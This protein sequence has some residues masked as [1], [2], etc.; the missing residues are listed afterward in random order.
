MSNKPILSL[1]GIVKRFGNQTV[2]NDFQLEIANGEFFTILGPSGCGKTT[3]LRLM[4]GFE[5]PDEGRI[6]LD[7]TDIAQ[8]APE[9]RPVNTVFQSYALFPHMSVFDNVAFGLNMA[10]VDKAEIDTRV[11]DALAMVRL[12]DYADRQPHQLSGGQRQRVAIARAVVNRPKVLLLDESLSA[13][14]A[15]L[16]QQM[17]VELK[18]LQR[19]LG[20]TFIYV[21]HDQEEALSMSDRILVMDGG[22]AQQV[23]TPR[24]I[25]ECPQNVFVASFIGEINAIDGVITEQ[26]EDLRYI[27]KMADHHRE[28]RTDKVFSVGDHIKILLRPEDLRIEY[29]EDAPDKPGFIGHVRERNYKGKTLDSIIELNNGMRLHASEFFDEDDPDFD[30]RLGQKVWVDWVHGWEHVIKSES[31]L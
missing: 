9:A 25:Y 8:V 5:L 17:Q 13:L 31:Q 6:E 7:G 15:K 10:K 21:T 23:G 14:D 22:V 29:I 26:L 27:A 24:E 28:I 12:A 16:R 3:V 30:Y 4:A 19:Q 2:L 20:I 11:R 1:S 18:M